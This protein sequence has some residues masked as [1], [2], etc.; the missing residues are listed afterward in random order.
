MSNRWILLE[1]IVPVDSL[2]QS[3]FDLLLEDIGGCRTWRL[4]VVPVLDGPPQPVTPLPMHRLYWLETSVS[5]VS[6][7]R[8]WARRVMAGVFL[9]DLP[10]RSS[11]SFQV[12]L[13]SHELI[14]KLEIIDLSCKLSSL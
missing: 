4:E 3:H 12:A 13:H 9:G 2:N 10:K 11:D 5:E 14:G 1:H 7:G 6:G 8:G